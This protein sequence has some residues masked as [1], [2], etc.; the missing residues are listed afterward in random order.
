MFDSGTKAFLTP[1]IRAVD[2]ISCIN[3]IAPFG[4][5]ARGLKADSA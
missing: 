2:G 4:D 3:P 1:S 5:T